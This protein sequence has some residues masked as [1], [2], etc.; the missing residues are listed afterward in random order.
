[1]LSRKDYRA[2]AEIV[3]RQAKAYRNDNAP[4]H[5]LGTEAVV[6]PFADYFG[7]DNSRFDRA[8]FLAACGL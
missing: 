5:A 1:M 4:G 8:R 7:Q 2:I 6:K 3:K